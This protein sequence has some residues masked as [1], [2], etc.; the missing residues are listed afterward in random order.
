[1][2]KVGSDRSRENGSKLKEGRFRFDVTGKFFTERV[3]WCWHRLP[4]VVVNAGSLEV[5]KARLHGVLGNL[6]YWLD[7]PVGNLAFSRKVGR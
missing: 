1:M 6:T 4:R 2:R 3:L 7:L 5:F